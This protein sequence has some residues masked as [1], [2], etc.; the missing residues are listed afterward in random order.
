MYKLYQAGKFGSNLPEIGGKI[1]SPKQILELEYFLTRSQAG[2]RMFQLEQCVTHTRSMCTF[3]I[4][5]D[6]QEA[7][8]LWDDQVL[9]FLLGTYTIQLIRVG[10]QD[11]LN[12]IR[13]ETILRSTTLQELLQVCS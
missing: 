2:T 13:M 7:H 6:N 5:G 3:A 8:I 9:V 1:P 10:K 11:V 4:K 12:D